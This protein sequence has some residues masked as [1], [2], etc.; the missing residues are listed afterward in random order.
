MAE[1]ARD[2]EGMEEKS[3][4]GFAASGG[5]CRVRLLNRLSAPRFPRGPQF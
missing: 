4:I 3:L 5:N 2:Y 1:A